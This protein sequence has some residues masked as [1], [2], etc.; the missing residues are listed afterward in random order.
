MHASEFAVSFHQIVCPL[1]VPSDAEQLFATSVTARLP[2]W[3]AGFVLRCTMVRKRPD[4]AFI[5]APCCCAPGGEGKFGSEGGGK[6]KAE[7]NE[8]SSV[9]LLPGHKATPLTFLHVLFTLGVESFPRTQ[10]VF[11]F[12][13]YEPK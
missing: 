13:Y 4:E 10:G 6:M 12:C 8:V 3:V 2:R 5:V 1:L 7:I 11:Y 9:S